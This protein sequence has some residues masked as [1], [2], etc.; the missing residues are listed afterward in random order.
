MTTVEMGGVKYSISKLLVIQRKLA[1]MMLA[2]YNAMND[3]EGRSRLRATAQ[4]QTGETPHVVRFYKEEDKREQQRKWQ[5][6]ID[7]I[8]TRL[9][10]INATT[11]LLDLP[12]MS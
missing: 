6:L 10:V 3:T 5:D 1:A 12:S 11:P 8:T 7:N 2:T 9:E 4:P